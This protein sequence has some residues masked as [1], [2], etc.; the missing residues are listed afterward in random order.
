MD[1]FKNLPYDLQLVI[2]EMHEKEN[3]LEKIEKKQKEIY[4]ELLDEFNRLYLAFYS[5]NHDS[6]CW[7]LLFFTLRYEKRMRG[8]EQ[9]P[10]FIM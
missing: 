5:D 4:H 9:Y 2:Y 6:W 7:D 10:T 1:I 3:K 8:A